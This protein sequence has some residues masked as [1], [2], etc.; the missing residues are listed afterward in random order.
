MVIN[1]KVSITYQTK[2]INL[3]TKAIDIEAINITTTDTYIVDKK[4]QQYQITLFITKQIQII[5]YL[6][7][8]ITNII[9][10]KPQTIL[11]NHH[12]QITPG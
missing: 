8:E 11:L 6:F 4:I 12:R 5:N 10:T 7:K 9:E 2:V 1:K 3:E